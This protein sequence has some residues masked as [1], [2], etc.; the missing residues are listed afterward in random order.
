[1]SVHHQAQLARGGYSRRSFLKYGAMGAAGASLA[2]A[3][4]G[5]AGT[6]SGNAAA[7]PTAKKESGTLTMWTWAA[8]G[9]LQSGFEA[10]IA[11]Y[12][13]EFS[14]VKVNVTTPATSDFQL[15]EQLTLALAGHT[16]IPDLVQLDYLELSQFAAAGVLESLDAFYPAST[17]DNLYS[18]ANVIN[19]YGNTYY[20]F[21]HQL[22][23]KLFYYRADMF[24]EAGIDAESI[25]TVDDY[26]SAG[27]K[28]T[29]KF[30]GQYIMNLDT[31][32]QEYMFDMPAGAFSPID[33]V[34]KSGHWD[35]T[36]NPA[37]LKVFEFL[38][39][40]KTSGIAYPAD[41]F[42]PDW[43]EAI[44]KEKICGLLTA[45]WMRDFLP[46]YAP[47]SS[48]GKWKAML[49]PTFEP[50]M[51][52]ERYGS[53]A[54]GSLFVV[55]QDAPNKDLALAIA[56]KATLDEKGSMIFFNSNGSTPLL[57]SLQ[58]EVID[59]FKTQ[60]RP[61]GMSAT[62]WAQLPQNFLGADYYKQEFDCY[63]FVKIFGYDPA[64]VKEFG[65]ILPEWLTKLLSGS[66]SPANALAGMQQAM[67]SQIGNPY[68]S[69]V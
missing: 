63:D 37:F 17:R 40:L 5:G 22:K 56:Q 53:D 6:A 41:D 46:G 34:N 3:G 30:P 43:P 55:F 18:G 24:E 25:Q 68:N 8:A 15:S 64:A 67:E 21:P 13:E 69:Q 2:L 39:Q 7:L 28:F 23:G 61:T 36:S 20:A 60:Q 11:A 33:F 62:A 65:T 19:K 44:Q 29:K 31:E 52:D 10:I 50:T 66:L 54:G 35:I 12:P 59:S 58:N 27:K 49:W 14:G 9:E 47:L 26:I 16:P 38:L 32:P 45:C 1:M 57:R 51:A 42:T 48:S 4:C